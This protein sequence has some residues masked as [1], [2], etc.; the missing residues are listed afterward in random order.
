MDL[1]ITKIKSSFQYWSV[2]NRTRT[3]L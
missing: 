3:K 2:S 1:I